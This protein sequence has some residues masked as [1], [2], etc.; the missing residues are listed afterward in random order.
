MTMGK[1]DQSKSQGSAPPLVRHAD[2][3]TLDWQ[4]RGG[5]SSL[6]ARPCRWVCVGRTDEDGSGRAAV[7]SS[8]LAVSPL[9]ASSATSR[10]SSSWSSSHTTKVPRHVPTDGFVTQLN[11]L[12]P[13]SGGSNGRRVGVVRREAQEQ[14]SY[15]R[16]VIVQEYR[17]A[18]DDVVDDDGYLCNLRS[19]IHYP[20]RRPSGRP[21]GAPRRSVV[22]R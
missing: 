6:R 16:V 3:R 1:D 12:A 22:N 2:R 18:D 5:Q 20:W 15:N 10:S 19:S 7:R 14:H 13:T 9:L 11:E 21:C 4:S 8:G 17:I